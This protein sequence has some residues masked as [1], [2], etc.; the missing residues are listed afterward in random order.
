MQID[1]TGNGME[2]TPDLRTFT[3]EKLQALLRHS[4]DLIRLKI[5]FESEK[6]VHTAKGS[7]HLSGNDIVASHEA[8]NL[9]KAVDGLV[10]KL[11][12]QLQKSKT[13]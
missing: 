4:P 5:T 11:N 12:R 2:V 8:E 13:S 6:L 1:I 10:D 3:E 9:Y 7:A